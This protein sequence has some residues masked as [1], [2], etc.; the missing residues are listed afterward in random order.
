MADA[1]PTPAASPARTASLSKP[2]LISFFLHLHGVFVESL[3][4]L[5]FQEGL[6]LPTCTYTYRQLQTEDEGMG[7]PCHLLAQL[8]YDCCA[9]F[10][11]GTSLNP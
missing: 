1:A 11:E 10:S 4:F 7:M 5:S 6:P 9:A 2:V 3:G 8:K